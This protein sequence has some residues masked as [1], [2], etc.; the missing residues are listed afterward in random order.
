MKIFFNNKFKWSYL[1]I[2]VMVVIITTV[3]ID[4]IRISGY[5]IYPVKPINKIQVQQDQVYYDLVQGALDIDW[6]RLYGTLEFINKEYDCSDFRLVNLIRILYDYEGQIPEMTLSRIKNTLF[7]FRYWWDGPGENSMCYWS[8]NHQILFA[9]AEYLVGQKYP[10]TVFPGS[11][12][13]GKEHL[14]L[15]RTR[16]LDWLEMRWKYGFTEFFSGVY[17]KEDIGAMINIIDYAEDA[18][19][20]KKTRI[21]MDLLFYDVATQNINTMFVSASGRAY[22]GNRKGGSGA[23]LGG[24][25]RYY[26]GSGEEIRSGMIYGMMVTDNY[27]LPP[28]LI[29]IGKDTSSVVIRQS[30]GLDISELKGEGYF[31]TDNKSMMMQ[32]GMEAFT[33]PEIVRNSLSLIRRN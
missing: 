7:G 8:E 22:T 24:L 17:Y 31:G 21:I 5:E 26:W 20:V 23:T 12:L 32:L 9:S 2:L 1:L 4:L 15:A 29:D 25:T 19:L 11:G 18:E 33:N 10:D 6:S 28:V 14:A 27:S 16:A 30:N 13:S 3:I